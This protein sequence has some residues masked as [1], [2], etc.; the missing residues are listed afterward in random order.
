M[1]YD[2]IIAIHTRL[3]H[4][5]NYVLNREKSDMA[6]VR[7]YIG[8]PEKTTLAEEETVLETAINCT[9]ETA[10]AD[11]MDTK[12]RWSKP[13]GVLGY[14]LI[15]SYAPG[16][17]TPQQAHEIGVE[18]ANR[19][20]GE[21]YEA[22]VSTH[23]DRNHL[24]CH[25]LFNSVSL[26]DGKKYQNTFKDYFGDIRGI[27][28]EASRAHDLSVIDP[29]GKG[30]HYA[31]W[32]AEHQGKATIRG[33]VRQDIDAAI[34]NA[35][36]YQSLFAILEKRGYTIKRGPNIQHTAVRPPG[37]VRF[38]RLDNLGAD[39]TETAIKERL[40][41]VRTGQSEPAAQTP[42]PPTPRFP[43]GRRYRVAP[44]AIPKQRPRLHGFRLLY[45]RYL[46]LL[47][48]R[49]PNRP[50]PFI[51]RQEV[52]RL[53]R[54]QRQFRFLQEYR[55]D[56]APQLSMLADALQAEIDDLTARRKELY[57]LKRNGGDVTADIAAITS[58]L[59]PLRHKLH[60]CGEI[61]ADIP[62]IQEQERLCREEPQGQKPKTQ[63]KTKRRKFDR[64]M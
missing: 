51:V 52:V 55:I 8:S 42:E 22:V 40:S 45:V 62:R 50:M 18:F 6:A 16:E 56:T 19:L 47:G 39:Y 37:G 53:H 31:E 57:R 35:F 33:L 2:K 17:V 46:Y 12:R 58:A 49:K 23:L 24:H 1:A 60:F 4:S 32:D 21:R 63:Q 25:I 20:L 29:Q 30:Q 27:S 64:W 15:H 48:I 13:G 34:A 44:G 7:A 26:V 9:L 28:N 5:V 38:L 59:R 10:C 36:T 3:D 41:A 43:P 54:Y 61:A 11:M 14:H